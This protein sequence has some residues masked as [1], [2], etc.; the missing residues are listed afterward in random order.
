MTTPV[1]VM[2]CTFEPKHTLERAL[3]RE[4]A[5][6]NGTIARLK[7]RSER[8]ELDFEQELARI[9]VLTMKH[10]SDDAVVCAECG[11]GMEELAA[12]EGITSKTEA[13]RSVCADFP[14]AIR[15]TRELR[16]LG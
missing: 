2:V 11:M 1:R 6:A 7:K 13:I 5:V 10:R 4:R 15:R 3:K 14:G 12:P 16:L 9:G 8:G